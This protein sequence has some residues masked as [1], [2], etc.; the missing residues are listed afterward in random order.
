MQ[1]N[2]FE[3]IARGVIETD[4]KILLCQV[5]GKRHRFFPG[6]HIE[7]GET[8][9]EALAR[10]LD[11]E[12]GV[13]IKS[14]EYIGTVENIFLQEGERHHEVNLVFSVI[15]QMPSHT[16]KE[17]HIEFALI[18]REEFK[19]ETILPV[20]LKESIIKWLSDGNIFFAT[21]KDNLYHLF[22][23]R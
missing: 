17:D 14:A 13:S 11:E 12:L 16:S 23:D 21:Q 10:E 7:F 4:G 18:D 5:K 9:R 20:A 15:L 6:G 19:N 2:N 22:C 8:A 1:Q 3:I